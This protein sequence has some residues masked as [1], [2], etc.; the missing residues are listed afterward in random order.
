MARAEIQPES[1]S[2][3][4]RADVSSPLPPQQHR[5]L[6]DRVTR[7]IELLGY[8]GEVRVRVVN[9]AAMA[10]AHEGFAGVPGTTDVLTFDLAEPGSN[11]LD[12]DILACYDEAVRQA[13]VRGH[14]PEQE[15]LLYIVHGVLHCLGHDDHDEAAAARMHTE[16]DRIL[17]AI[18]VGPTYA[19]KSSGEATA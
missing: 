4:A 14:A 16:E 15:L 19:G 13:A 18:G 3:R 9:D 11:L 1:S 6:T 2:G 5:W 10:A 12:V 7:A 8:P 17:T